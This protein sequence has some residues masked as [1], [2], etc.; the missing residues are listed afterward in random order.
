MNWA[1]LIS[2]AV[3]IG[4]AASVALGQPALGAVISNPQTATI[5]TGLVGVIGAAVS[6][7]SPPVHKAVSN[8]ASS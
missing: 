5:L 3:S 2:A 7:F 8:I 6:A 1:A 4:S